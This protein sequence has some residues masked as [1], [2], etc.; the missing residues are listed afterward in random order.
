MY[1]REKEKKKKKKTLLCQYHM[2]TMC[3]ITD[4]L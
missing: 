1:K 3:E 4:G 2:T